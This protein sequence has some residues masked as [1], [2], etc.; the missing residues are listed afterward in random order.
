M[1]RSKEQMAL[2]RELVTSTVRQIEDT[3]PIPGWVLMSEED[4]ICAVRD[5]LSQAAPGPIW[6]FAYGSLLW[7]PA[8]EIVE[9]RPAVVRG[10]HRAFCFRVPRFRG[11]PDQPGLMM[12]LDRGGQCQGMIFQIANPVEHSLGKLFRREW[13]VKPSVNLPRWLTAQTKS[14]VS[15]GAWVRG[16]SSG[17]T[18]RRQTIA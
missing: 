18:L 10:W 9:R 8:C 11:T 12:A 15:S 13:T 5:V 14:W 17:S 16:Q 3:G 2:T 1:P 4:Y 6:L 7:K